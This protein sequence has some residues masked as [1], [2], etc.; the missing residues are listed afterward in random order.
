MAEERHIYDHDILYEEVCAEPMQVVAMRY[1]VSDVVL[2]KTCRRMGVPVPGCGH[3]AKLKAGRAEA[4]P[5]LPPPQ[6]GQPEQ[7]RI[8][9]V[10]KP[11][12]PE[13]L[14]E[15]SQPVPIET[16]EPIV[17]NPALAWY[18]LDEHARAL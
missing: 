10:E 2:A 14:E 18:I 4:R 17:V 15:A 12:P 3:W 16:S 13:W 5:P 9:R 7:A 8:H 11:E 1:G 6:P